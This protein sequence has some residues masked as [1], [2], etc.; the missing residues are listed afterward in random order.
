MGI[1]RAARWLVALLAVAVLAGVAGAG[2]WWLT[3]VRWHWPR[4]D[5]I[6][7]VAVVVTVVAAL[8][9]VPV[10]AWVSAE[11]ARPVR[12]GTGLIS[13]LLAPIGP[14]TEIDPTMIGVDR[15]TQQVLPGGAVPTYVE[16]VIDAQLR[17]AIVAAVRG[18]GPWLVVVT[19]PSKVGKSRTLF[20][21]LRTVSDGL[22]RPLEVV[23]PVDSEAVRVLASSG[24]SSRRD[25]APAV[26]WLDDLEPFLNQGLSFQILSQWHAGGSHRVVAATY[27]GKGSE[28]VAG[29]SVAGLA[30]IAAGVL[31]HARE[32]PLAATTTDEIASCPRRCRLARW[33]PSSGT[34][35]PRT[36]WRDASWNANWP[37]HGIHRTKRP[38]LKAWRWCPR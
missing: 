33:R 29:S 28:L 9:V 4:G 24:Q 3:D 17:G 35:W 25:R 38:V 27:G 1:V 31:Q 6:P 14:I 7:T 36:W 21:A 30:T 12:A 10:P 8:C 15:A 22:R 34:G 16:R 23:A 32:I 19:G 5:V 2:V 11:P 13:S 37:P 20:E 26:L 18:E